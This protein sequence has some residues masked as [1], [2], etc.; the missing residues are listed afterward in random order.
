MKKDKEYTEGVAVQ[1]GLLAKLDNY[2][3]HY[4]W[5]TIIVAFLLIVVVICTVQMCTKETYDLNVV[6]AGSE[7]L[8][9]EESEGIKRALN[10][11]V[12]AE[13]NKGRKKALNVGFVDYYLLSDSQIAAKQAEILAEKEKAEETGKNPG[14]DA[15]VLDMSYIQSENSRYNNYIQTGESSI[16]LIEKWEYENLVKYDRLA[17]LSDVIGKKPENAYSDYAVRLG[18]TALYEEFKV[19]QKIDDDTLICILKPVVVGGKN[20]KEE[21]YTLD[22]QMFAAMIAPK[23]ETESD[24]E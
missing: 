5:P 4:K 6:Y 18:D 13:M 7:D 19:M 22:K 10:A 1:G 8:T 23:A 14:Y 3:Y 20:S 12:P 15:K 21:Q 17:P 2:W 9:D 11:Y 16:L 24:G